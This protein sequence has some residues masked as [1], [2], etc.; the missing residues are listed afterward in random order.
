VNVLII[1]AIYRGYMIKRVFPVILVLI[2]L[3]FAGCVNKDSEASSGNDVSTRLDALE[4]KVAGQAEQ[5]ASTGG[6]A[7]II[8]YDT[9]TL[10]L[11]VHGTGRSSLV[12]TI[13]GSGLDDRLIA[14]T[15][16]ST[17][18]LITGEYLPC[19]TVLYVVVSPNPGWDNN[20]VTLDISALCEKG[21]IDYIT[22]QTGA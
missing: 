20:V 1:T 2:L 12:V 19:G 15:E 7:E 4:L 17:G 13:L 14:T 16:G 6:Y 18:Y 10:T 21:S 8:D 11:Q 22:V 5:L 9:D 3:A